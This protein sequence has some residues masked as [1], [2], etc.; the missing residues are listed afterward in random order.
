[1]KSAMILVSLCLRHKNEL[2]M[3]QVC[4]GV[5]AVAVFA[6]VL[7]GSPAFSQP[8]STAEN[9]FIKTLLDE[10][11][12]Y[13]GREITVMGIVTDVKT[14]FAYRMPG[15][16]ND[17]MFNLKDESGL[18]HVVASGPCDVDKV[19]TILG[20]GDRVLV[21]GILEQVPPRASKPSIPYIRGTLT[22]LSP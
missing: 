16:C 19:A 9:V 14:L 3:P 20:N 4:M 8:E 11:R 1:M 21:T 7:A 5:I 6:G 18:I 15:A 10:T 13:Q 2:L 17:Y 12:T 22:R